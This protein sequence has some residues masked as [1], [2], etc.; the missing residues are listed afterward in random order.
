MAIHSFL[1]L[2]DI[3]T[4]L[5]GMLMSLAVRFF[6]QLAPRITTDYPA[7]ALIPLT[8]ISPRQLVRIVHSQT[9][10]LAVAETV[11]AFRVHL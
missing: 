6:L 3:N 11:E 8:K 4:F 7:G 9:S 5:F 10:S 2:T 1:Y